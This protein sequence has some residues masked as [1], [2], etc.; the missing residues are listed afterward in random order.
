M[1]R[2]SLIF[3]AFF[4]RPAAQPV[5]FTGAFLIPEQRVWLLLK[6]RSVYKQL[7]SLR[8]FRSFIGALIGPFF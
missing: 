4:V 5:V 2:G 7:N 1:T 3:P 6:E 8:V